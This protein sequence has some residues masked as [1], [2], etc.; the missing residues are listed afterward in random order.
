[1][2]NG[3]MIKMSSTFRFNLGSH[4]LPI[5]IINSLLL[6]E[7]KTRKLSWKKQNSATKWGII[8]K[9]I[10]FQVQ[11]LGFWA[12]TICPLPETSVNA[13]APIPTWVHYDK[14]C[15]VYII[16][17][18]LPNQ[19]PNF[20]TMRQLSSSFD[21]WQLVLDFYWWFLESGARWV[22]SMEQA[23]TPTTGDT[24]HNEIKSCNN[25]DLKDEIVILLFD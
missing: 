24:H 15:H 8:Q 4:H 12:L 13:L 20:H 11:T 19:P 5:I 9:A 2:K 16:L 17:S 22:P 7:L 18:V 25:Q 23:T 10:N 3:E 1:M 21:R 14:S 6:C